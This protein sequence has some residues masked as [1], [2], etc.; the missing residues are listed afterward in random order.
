MMAPF[1][2]QDCAALRRE[3]ESLADPAYKAFNESL[4][5]GV[6]TAYGIRLPQMRQ[7][8]KT[9][10]RQDPAG[11]LEH[12]QPNCYEETQLRG[13]VIGGMKL[14]WEEKRPLVEDF[15]PRIDNWAVCDTFCGSLKPRSPQD[16]PLMWEFLKPLYASDEEYKARFA[17]VMQLSH[18]VDAAHLEEGLGLLGQVRHPGYYAKMAVAWAL[19]VWFVKFPQETESLLAQRAF[20][21][22]VQN[23]AI[24]KVRESRRVSKED[25][26]RL[27]SYKL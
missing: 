24:Q 5:P 10:L 27:L 1:S 4:L 17:A 14:P 6:E 12:F 20:D 23:K 18:F 19:S 7:V 25:K 16:V 15:L 13:L 2:P 3:L 9:L 21:P 8:A 26:D 11:F 22:W